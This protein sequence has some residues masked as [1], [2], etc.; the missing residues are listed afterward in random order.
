M[1][2]QPSRKYADTLTFED[3][4]MSADGVTDKK[5]KV[6]SDYVDD[7]GNVVF[8]EGSI[9]SGTMGTNLDGVPGIEGTNLAAE[10]VS[11]MG[12]SIGDIAEIILKDLGAASDIYTKFKTGSPGGTG[13]TKPTTTPK[14]PASK[15]IS[16]LAIGGIAAG[17]VLLGTIVW[18]ITKK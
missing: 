12:S 9:V 10:D 11:Q 7:S 6:L 16:P 17:F 14:P 18:Y 1:Y 13:T 2:I 3:R 15:G 5:Y 4:Y 8:A